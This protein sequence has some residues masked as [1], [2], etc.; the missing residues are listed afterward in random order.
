MSLLMS[1]TPLLRRSSEG[2]PVLHSVP[3]L[4][5]PPCL[6]GITSSDFLSAASATNRGVENWTELTALLE[7][8]AKLSPCIAQSLPYDSTWNIGGT[9]PLILNLGTKC[10]LYIYRKIQQ[11]RKAVRPEF[12]AE[13]FGEN[14]L[15]C[16][17]WIHD[18]LVIQHVLSRSSHTSLS[19]SSSSSS[20][21]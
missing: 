12:C 4:C 6:A 5:L 1:C 15:T 9:D 11:R 14:F 3:S 13:L 7:A 16:E 2:S 20:E 10:R 21:R 17:E 19:S 18:P 8:E